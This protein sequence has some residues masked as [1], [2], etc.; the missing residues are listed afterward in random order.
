[1][2]DTYTVQIPDGTEVEIPVDTPKEKVRQI[3]GGYIQKTMTPE[4]IDAIPTS[5]RLAFGLGQGA[6]AA[7]AR[8]NLAKV[9]GEQTEAQYGEDVRG[10][11]AQGVREIGTPIAAGAVGLATA[12]VGLPFAAGLMATTGAVGE[13]YA[14]MGAPTASA[15]RDIA[16]AGAL[17]GLS[18]VGGRLVAGAIGK[19][20]ARKVAEGAK[21]AAEYAATAERLGFPMKNVESKVGSSLQSR[22]DAARRASIAKEADEIM[23]PFGSPLTAEMAGQ[24]AAGVFK[25]IEDKF[26]GRARDLRNFVRDFELPNGKKMGE[27]DALLRDTI[28]EAAKVQKELGKRAFKGMEELDPFF[29]AMYEENGAFKRFTVDEALALRTDIGKELAKLPDANPKKTILKKLY[30]AMSSDIETSIDLRDPMLGETF[31]SANR[32][33]AMYFDGLKNEVAHRMMS[34]AKDGNGTAVVRE[35][36]KGDP[37]AIN[38]VFQFVQ[39]TRPQD[40]GQFRQTVQRAALQNIFGIAEDGTPA[41]GYKLAERLEKIGPDRLDKIFSGSKEAAE[42][43]GRVKELAKLTGSFERSLKIPPDMSRQMESGVKNLIMQAGVAMAAKAW[44]APYAAARIGAGALKGAGDLILAELA[45]RPELFKQF[46]KGW[47]RAASAVSNTSMIAGTR[48][49]L[50]KGGESLM[51]G[52]LSAAANA[53]AMEEIA[54]AKRAKVQ[55]DRAARENAGRPQGFPPQI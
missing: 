28:F 49:S 1:M 6:V 20:A 44:G 38:Q 24:E 50:R 22:V 40:M 2:A 39:K 34:A 42:T 35:F 52:A 14:Q 15:G 36:F 7:Q 29:K 31:K 25:N 17:G 4:Q 21:D 23:A 32:D 48:E 16:I 11:W 51:K 53:V 46:T 26:V 19:L 5:T 54:K 33:F 10:V 8:K 37:E 18:E 43:L 12:G 9:Q 45:V 30:G 3:V 47:Q 13:T 55:Q 41:V 27:S